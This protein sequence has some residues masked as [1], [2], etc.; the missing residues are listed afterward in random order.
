MQTRE[1]QDD[2]SDVESML[3]QLANGQGS[4]SQ[5]T[6]ICNRDALLNCLNEILK[7]PD[8]E[9]CTNFPTEI[10]DRSLDKMVQLAVEEIKENTTLK[11]LTK[12]I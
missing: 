1:S 3:R 5:D 6:N 4:V 2:M 12:A 10:K 8:F 11:T 7:I 9:F